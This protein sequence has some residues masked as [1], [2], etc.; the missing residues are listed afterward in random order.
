MSGQGGSSSQQVWVWCPLPGDRDT[1]LEHPSDLPMDEATAKVRWVQGRRGP[2]LS[3]ISPATLIQTKG[4][5]AL[6]AEAGATREIPKSTVLPWYEGLLLLDELENSSDTPGHLQASWNKDKALQEILAQERAKFKVLSGAL[7]TERRLVTTSVTGA[8]FFDKDDREWAYRRENVNGE[9]K[10]G[11]VEG[12]DGGGFWRVKEVTDYLPPWEAFSHERCG[13][14]QDFYQVRWEHPFSEID[15][16]KVENGSTTGFGATWEPDECLPA[17]LDP[18]RL[19]AKKAWIKRHREHE[20]SVAQQ[21]LAVKRPGASPPEA[22]KRQRSDLNGDDDHKGNEEKKP[23]IPKKRNKRDGKKLDPDM[24][25]LTAGHDFAPP[26][27]LEM[28]GNIRSG[29]PK[30]S[31]DYPRGYGVANPPGFCWD[32]CDCMDDRRPQRSWETH[33]AWLEEAERTKAANACIELF[34][35][36]TKFVRRRGQVSKMCFFETAQDQRPD[37]THQR[38]ALSLA[39]SVSRRVGEVM[40]AIPLYS[41]MTD[42]SPPVT[43]PTSAFLP[44]DMDVEPLRYDATNAKTGEQL[45][46][47]FSI[48]PASGAMTA[49]DGVLLAESLEMKIDLYHSEG[50]VASASCIIT[51]QKAM[52]PTAPWNI[53]TAAIIA[54]FE[55]TDTCPLDKMA[56]NVLQERL[57]GLYDF[58]SKAVR[59]VS[60]GQW[61]QTI[62][63]LLRM[64]KSSVVA[65]ITPTAAVAEDLERYAKGK[66]FQNRVREQFSALTDQK[67]IVAR[68]SKM[69]DLLTQKDNPAMMNQEKVQE[70]LA[71]LEKEFLAKP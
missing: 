3:R 33:K 41:L 49:T 63:V 35:Q 48:D 47:W 70:F 68:L 28:L 10:S 38:A 57:M 34:S 50:T 27:K 22:V 52:P 13:F 14:Y 51:P 59:L 32:G 21:K 5:T 61:L 7:Y 29:W 53:A 20:K 36:Q 71:T 18:L 40:R 37:L 25:I 2:R 45:P 42:V 54:R 12:E 19:A 39:G 65:V 8:S 6:I 26:E 46:E 69:R 24:F 44:D 60:L 17:H 66:H 1:I 23:I 30:T 43:L 64:L 4:T 9:D 62:T 67:Q 55:N 58:N 16:S 31:M 15:Y 56:R 11:L